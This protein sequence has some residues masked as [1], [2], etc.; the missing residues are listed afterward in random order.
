MLDVL[1]CVM[2]E[3]TM[4]Q[5]GR[6]DRLAEICVGIAANLACHGGLARRVLHARRLRAAALQHLLWRS[7]PAFLAEACRHA[8]HSP[9]KLPD[10]NQTLTH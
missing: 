9:Q 1:A 8:T 6:S 3:S 10:P 2:D 4:M 5:G 7:D